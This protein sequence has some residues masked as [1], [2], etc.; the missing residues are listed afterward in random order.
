MGSV[1]AHHAGKPIFAVATYFHAARCAGGGIAQIMLETQNA[2]LEIN[3]RKLKVIAYDDLVEAAAHGTTGPFLYA[4]CFAIRVKLKSDTRSNEQYNSLIRC[5]TQRCRGISL[6]LLDAR[7]NIKKAIGVG[8]R[9][10]ST[11]WSC[12]RER[13]QHVL[14]DV[15]DNMSSAGDAHVDDRWA[16]PPPSEGLLASGAL[17]NRMLHHMPHLAASEEFKWAFRQSLKLHRFLWVAGA[18]ECVHISTTDRAS[19]AP[20]DYVWFV[21]EKDRTLGMMTRCS[22]SRDPLK[23]R[24]FRV[25]LCVPLVCMPIVEVFQTYYAQAHTAG[26][27]RPAVSKHQLVWR[28]NPGDAHPGE[29]GTLYADLRRTTQVLF[30]LRKTRSGVGKGRGRGRGLGAAAPPPQP[31]ADIDSDVD[32]AGGGQ[33]RGCGSRGGRGRACSAVW[34]PR[35]GDFSDSDEDFDLEAELDQEMVRANAENFGDHDDEVDLVSGA[36]VLLEGIDAELEQKLDQRE[37]RAVG[38]VLRQSASSSSGPAAR[39]TERVARRME[40]RLSAG[41]SQP[42]GDGDGAESRGRDLDKTSYDDEFDDVFLSELI[43]EPVRGILGFG[44]GDALEDSVSDNHLDDIF[45]DMSGSDSDRA[46]VARPPRFGELEPDPMDAER[47]VH[48]KGAAMKGL[49]LL[50]D[51]SKARG[52]IP[53]GGHSTESP[54]YEM[55][56]VLAHGKSSTD[57][58]ESV[59]SLQFVSWVLPRNCSGRPVKVNRHS[60]VATW[61]TPAIVRTRC[62]K[63]AFVVHPAIGSTVVKTRHVV[64]MVSER[65]LRLRDMWEAALAPPSTSLAPVCAGCPNGDEVESI[66]MCPVCLESWHQRCSERLRRSIGSESE[67][68]GSMGTVNMDVWPTLWGEVQS[69]PLC[70]VCAAWLLR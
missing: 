37:K 52:A 44:S 36:A 19:V 31:L 17:Q 18:T 55:S 15:V 24:A 46:S 34:E 60:R 20:G 4:A 43:R 3:A 30:H 1:G 5:I 69:P 26:E 22:V 28:Y 66:Q 62:Y 67:L 56:L 39:V 16:V 68:F 57:D 54:N 70:R 2:N 59:S 45:G 48:W 32:I 40:E 38:E 41:V 65:M 13:A 53:L 11:K 49:A 47:V 9:G 42:G 51:S 33:G 29:R 21:S 23:S 35:P 12:L 58:S 7:C 14:D 61:P 10:A 6:Q 63:D 25:S 8:T 50:Q 27:C 64:S